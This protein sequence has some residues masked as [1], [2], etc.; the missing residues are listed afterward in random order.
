M[1]AALVRH[2]GGALQ[3]AS[4]PPRTGTAQ[5]AAESR[6][7]WSQVKVSVR[8]CSHRARSVNVGAAT[9]CKPAAGGCIDVLAT[10][11][12]TDPRYRLL[13]CVHVSCEGSQ[14][15]AY[16]WPE[17]LSRPCVVVL[18]YM[19][20]P[21]LGCFTA[22]AAL[23][24]VCQV[25]LVAKTSNREDDYGAHTAVW[26]KAAASESGPNGGP[27]G[28][29]AGSNRTLGGAMPR[30]TTQ[31]RDADSPM[32]S[33]SSGAPAVT[34]GQRSPQLHR[35]L[36]LAGRKG[37]HPLNSKRPIISHMATL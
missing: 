8:L 13:Q 24:V 5:P 20:R 1:A 9:C 35:P 12:A 22:V 31:N 30:T 27:I 26:W 4:R 11:D 28:R 37:G 17:T 3:S 6:P 10:R 33:N 32:I 25:L 29:R 36:P 16:M 21:V 2:G 34:S 23:F 19:M 14:F 18:R 15:A 7:S